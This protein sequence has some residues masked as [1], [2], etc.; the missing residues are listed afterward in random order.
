MTV[1]DVPGFHDALCPRDGSHSRA[2]E[3][4]R[5]LACAEGPNDAP[6]RGAAFRLV[7]AV[8]ANLPPPPSRPS[9][10]A[11]RWTDLA[12]ACVRGVRAFAATIR[13][14][15]VRGDSESFFSSAS[16]ATTATARLLAPATRGFG[17]PPP[18]PPPWRA[19]LLAAGVA[20][21]LREVAESWVAAWTTRALPGGHRL[22]SPFSVAAADA[23]VAVARLANPGDAP[24]LAPFDVA[25]LARACVAAAALVAPRAA[26]RDEAL[27]SILRDG[28]TDARED[29]SEQKNAFVAAAGCAAG[30]LVA[31]TVGREAAVAVCQLMDCEERGEGGGASR[32]EGGGASRGEG[33]GALSSAALSSASSASSAAS[34]ELDAAT[35]AFGGNEWTRRVALHLS[36]DAWVTPA[37]ATLAAALARRPSSREALRGAGATERVAETLARL[38]RNAAERAEASFAAR[39]DDEDDDDGREGGGGGGGG[40]SHVGRS[41]SGPRLTSVDLDDPDV[42]LPPRSVFDDDAYAPLAWRPGEASLVASCV[43]ALAEL[44]R[45]ADAT[46]AA[47]IRTAVPALAA[48]V[49]ALASEEAAESLGRGLGEETRCWATLATR[50]LRA[51]PGVR[52]NGRTP[53]VAW[54]KVAVAAALADALPAT[55]AGD[56]EDED[57]DAAETAAASAASPAAAPN[58]VF[59]HATGERTPAHAAILAARCPALLRGV[60][61]ADADRRDGSSSP[62]TTVRVARLGAGVTA[63]ALHVALTWAYSGAT[64]IDFAAIDDATSDEASTLAAVARSCGLRDLDATLRARRPA[65]GARV[66]ALTRDL[67]ALVRPTVRHSDLR[68]E[69]QDAVR[70]KD[71]HDGDVDDVDAARGDDSTVELSAHAVVMCARSAYCRAA[72]SPTHG[73]AESA[74][75]AV[76]SSSR[77]TLRLPVSTPSALAALRDACYSG[78]FPR[79]T[80]RGDGS[81]ASVAV[82]LAAALEYLTMDA[83]AEACASRLTQAMRDA[84]WRET[85]GVEAATEALTRATTLRRWAEAEAIADAVVDAYP[86]AA[87]TT[88]FETLG[89]EMRE[90]MRKAHVARARMGG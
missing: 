34:S 76:S 21:A 68:L 20:G 16:F 87:K 17:D 35:R 39:R 69:A 66:G 56:V 23:F 8:A 90:A 33:G 53:T 46:D 81:W 26:R 2:A 67:D 74:A 60:D 31:E 24:T 80:R 48:T 78:V 72:L 62:G 25:A 28:K 13:G 82:E 15:D 58:V 49:R 61:A 27:A 40:G 79:P 22:D 44:A 75:A 12:R 10:E 47:A 51:P 50:C 57:D 84:S 36:L 45:N 89:E 59:R 29:A 32:G 3:A 6:A 88:A 5:A 54:G 65:L 30:N 41:R 70:G 42:D 71:A 64:A 19:T 77:A 73:F 7:A 18:P 11:R 43:R 1:R 63:R 85:V 52:S 37:K 83:E 55:Y 9:D 86:E 14:E 4:A 38:T